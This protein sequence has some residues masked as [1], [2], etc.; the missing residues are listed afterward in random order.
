V[1]PPSPKRPSF[2]PAYAPAAAQ[3]PA[4]APAPAPKSRAEYAQAYRSQRAEQAQSYRVE[5]RDYD[6]HDYDRA[7]SAASSASG[8]D[9]RSKIAERRQRQHA[10]QRKNAKHSHAG[11]G[12]PTVDIGSAG[13][14][15]GGAVARRH[16]GR[17]V[18]E[19]VMS[20]EE[21]EEAHEAEPYSTRQG[22]FGGRDAF[23]QSE[24][25]PD[26]AP[27]RTDS[28]RP[29]PDHA[30]SALLEQLGLSHITASVARLGCSSLRHLLDLT[31]PDME[32][33][34]LAPLEARRLAHAIAALRGQQPQSQLTVS[35]QQL[36]SQT[37]AHSMTAPAGGH[38]GM[39][40]MT[41]A[42]PTMMVPTP[43]PMQTQG[44]AGGGAWQ[45]IL[46]FAE[47]MGD[48]ELL[49]EVRQRAM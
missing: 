9:L 6:R 40:S 38:S 48:A 10:R 4:P 36:Q 14:Q 34:G 5:Q 15:S 33:I 11:L 27:Q 7:S 8:Y 45:D 20:S 1:A 44:P 47:S 46:R 18:V 17:Y 24:D 35:P 16:G 42:Q 32:A 43:M 28:G 37:M 25:E 41:M 49:S 3:A 22:H 31:P 26:A 39:M 29:A 2:T 12:Q 13:W 19:A 21:E 30:L 23:S